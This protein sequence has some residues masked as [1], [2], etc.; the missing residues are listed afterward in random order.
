MT[1]TTISTKTCRD[2]DTF[3]ILPAIIIEKEE[4]DG[5]KT[6][7]LTLSLGR[8]AWVMTLERVTNNL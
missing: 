6:T 3:A 2:L 5:R 7:M 8:R 1:T 4:R